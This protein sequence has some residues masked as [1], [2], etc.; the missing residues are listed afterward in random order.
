M[1]DTRCILADIG[2]SVHNGGNTSICNQSRCSLLDTT[3][4][5]VRLDTHTLVDAW[6]SPTRAEIKTALDNGQQHKNCSACWAE[7]SAGRTSK[8]QLQNQHFADVEASLDQPR[9]LFLKPGNVCNLA[10]RHC[11][12]QVSSR[13]YADYYA[14]EVQD[15]TF[16]E[17]VSRFNP[18]RDSYADNNPNWAILKSWSDRVVFYDLYGAEPLLIEPVYDL[19]KHAA[20]T[21]ASVDQE[22]HINTNGTMWRDEYYKV[23]GQYKSVSLDLSIDGIGQQFDY[24][25][26]PARWSDML[27]NLKR[28]R[29]LAAS[30]PTIKIGITVT[31]S[32]Y[33]I[34]YAGSIRDYFEQELNFGDI[35]FNIVHTPDYM[36][37]RNAP[38]L[39]K[40][41][42]SQHLNNAGGKVTE[43]IS[44]LNSDIDNAEQNLKKFFDYTNK[45]DQLRE[46]S[47]AKTFPEMYQLLK[48]YQ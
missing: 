33:N 46:Q 45:Y 16:K 21:G 30:I 48:D 35:G 42:I 25:R 34:Y 1:A 18:T 26:Y 38:A 20:D 23:F 10:C 37:M 7:E 9:V 47:Y 36:D 19:I 32:L 3:N 22:I 28:Y 8:R 13:W 43:N 17:W 27:V 2:L 6:S 15:Q 24:M 41:I 44:F 5:P 40:Q 4:T 12:P 11:D 29:E 39:V 14:V 31:L